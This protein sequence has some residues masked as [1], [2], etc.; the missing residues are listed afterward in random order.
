[1]LPISVLIP[2]RDCGALM[3]GHLQSLKGWIDLAEEVVVVDSDS[4]DGAVEMLRRGLAHPRLRCLSHPP[5]LYQSWNFGIQHI[6][7]QYFYIST[8]GDSITREGLEHLLAVAEEFQSGVVISKP[9]FM[10]EDT[11]PAADIR[12]PIDDL[13][14][15]LAVTRPRAVSWLECLLFTAVHL[16][17]TLLG[18]SASNLY[19]TDALQKFPF[20]ADFGKAGDAAWAAR[21]FAD[22]KWAVTPRKFSTFLRHRDWTAAAERQ[23]W[24]TSTRLDQVLREA[25]QTAAANGVLSRAELEA[26][27]VAELLDAAGLWLDGKQAFDLRRARRWP[28]HLNPAAWSA[29]SLRNRQR[30]RLL[31]WRDRALVRL[32]TESAAGS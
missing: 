2:T 24:K 22:L 32:R 1:M 23:S 18:S 16:D 21:H 25:V 14:Q 31:Q 15:T 4:K 10:A 8:V 3:P 5:G 6:S 27:A 17:G 20:P 26:H 29:R 11:R 7:A 30:R 19:R 12:W 9:A 28:W 13:I